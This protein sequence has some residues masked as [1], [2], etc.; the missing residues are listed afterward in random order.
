MLTAAQNDN[1]NFE[2]T[3]KSREEKRTVDIEGKSRCRCE[4]VI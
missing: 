2:T 3:A 1:G 4:D